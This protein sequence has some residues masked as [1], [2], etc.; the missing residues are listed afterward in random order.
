VRLKDIGMSA[1]AAMAIWDKLAKFFV[2]LNT[3][4]LY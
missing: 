3:S 4:T 1:S 2:A